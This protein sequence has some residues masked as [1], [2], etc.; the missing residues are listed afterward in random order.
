MAEDV[1]LADVGDLC[2]SRRHPAR[3]RV[4]EELAG[5]LLDLHRAAESDG[6]RAGGRVLVRVY[7]R[8]PRSPAADVDLHGSLAD[9]SLRLGGNGVRVGAVGIELRVVLGDD[10]VRR[11]RGLPER[12]RLTERGGRVSVL[13][14][15]LLA[16]LL[17]HRFLRGGPR[18][19]DPERAVVVLRRLDLALRSGF[20]GRC[21]NG[22]V[23]SE[24][25]RVLAE[26]P[27]DVV[28]R[29]DLDLAHG[30]VG[31]DVLRRVLRLGD[32]LH[33]RVVEGAV[34]VAAG[35]RDG[36]GDA[37]LAAGRKG[38]DVRLVPVPRREHLLGTA[39]LRHGVVAV[40]VPLVDEVL[41]EGVGSVV[42]LDRRLRVHLVV[43]VALPRRHRRAVGTPDL[44]AVVDDAGIRG[45]GE[46]VF[47]RLLYES[48]RNAFHKTTDANRHVHLFARGLVYP[49]PFGEHLEP[50]TVLE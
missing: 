43:V 42:A 12:S 39:H 13:E 49:E 34:L 31:L 23:V 15:V 45:L 28:P 41:D 18:R 1:D 36:V 8:A 37:L 35:R 14:L 16:R 29:L 40:G 25:V 44:D 24:L 48:P 30:V 2:E 26:S 9:G 6:R 5:G 50:P 11:L 10:S 22:E 27:V 3:D 33:E 46:K 21:R 20:S 19:R 32:A 17:R 4:V 7:D 47:H 38:L